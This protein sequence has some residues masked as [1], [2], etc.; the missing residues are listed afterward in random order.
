MTYANTILSDSHVSATH[1]IGD[2]SRQRTLGLGPGR[3]HRGGGP[4]PWAKRCALS[5]A[6]SPSSKLVFMV[7]A[8]FVNGPDEAAWPS[9][10]TLAEMT[11][12]TARGVRNA[13]KQLAAAG[14]IRV[15]QGGGDK[16]IRYRLTPELSSPLPRNSVPPPPE[17]TSPEVRT[18]EVPSTRAAQPLPVQTIGSERNT[19]A[20]CGHDWPSV[21]GSRCYS[22]RGKGKETSLAAPVPGKYEEFDGDDAPRPDP[23]PMKT[24]LRRDLEA[25]A[26]SNGYR[27]RGERWSKAGLAAHE[28]GKYAEFD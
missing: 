21:Y 14:L 5:Q 11:G 25:E 9:Q 2:S 23:P 17:L 6:P 1:E 16:S 7:L 3:V 4:V 8:S 12:L 26:I 20:T 10:S 28:P 24:E 18:N 13:T 19:C 15:E 22:C 27:K